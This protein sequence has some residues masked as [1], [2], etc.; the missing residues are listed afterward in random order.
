MKITRAYPDSL[1]FEV[2]TGDRKYRHH[3]HLDDGEVS[4][5]VTRTSNGHR[6]EIVLAREWAEGE[7]ESAIDL[8]LEERKRWER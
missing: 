8:A 3:I 1:L 7:L 6:T 2:A 4:I 5:R